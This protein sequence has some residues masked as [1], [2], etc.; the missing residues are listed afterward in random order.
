MTYSQ[1]PTVA[2]PQAVPTV[3]TDQKTQPL[4]KVPKLTKR[5]RIKL[6]Q[7]VL[8]FVKS[9]E[10]INTLSQI[11]EF[12][13]LIN[14][15]SLIISL[16]SLNSATNPE[17][18]RS[19][20]SSH[21]RITD[22]VVTFNLDP[23]Y[24]KTSYDSRTHEVAKQVIDIDESVIKA[25]MRGNTSVPQ[26]VVVEIYIENDS[27]FVSN[28]LDILDNF[29]FSRLVDR[30]TNQRK[31]GRGRR[32]KA[33]TGT[34]FIH[35][36]V[37]KVGF[38][39]ERFNLGNLEEFLD[40]YK[41]GM[42]EWFNFGEPRA[43][44]YKDGTVPASF[45]QQQDSAEE[46]YDWCYP[47]QT[48]G[49]TK[50]L[51]DL[52]NSRVKFLSGKNYQSHFNE[53]NFIEN[54]SV[55]VITFDKFKP[56]SHQIKYAYQNQQSMIQYPE[57]EVLDLCSEESIRGNM[58]QFNETF[59]NFLFSYFKHLISLNMSILAQSNGNLASQGFDLT[60]LNNF[61]HF[62]TFLISAYCR[63]MFMKPENDYFSLSRYFASSLE[64]KLVVKDLRFDYFNLLN[65]LNYYKNDNGVVKTCTSF[66]SSSSFSEIIK[67]SGII[68]K[69]SEE[70]FQYFINIR[71]LVFYNSNSEVQIEPEQMFR[72]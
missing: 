70:L 64:N 60:K 56:V 7:N 1:E 26:F 37:I 39:Q 22:N 41:F 48:C 49:F 69:I 62:K 3:E 14:D 46:Y 20:E 10:S 57:L 9:Y 50:A 18:W 68:D 32:G 33:N 63:L 21:D 4:K 19:I 59:T 55:E 5:A 12:Q 67:K 45:Q 44:C 42:F 51:F 16:N 65:S 52:R 13:S 58:L 27:R 53:V 28:P 6:L 29:D 43:V 17:L 40:I 15:S 61:E 8:D 2:S 23:S 34:N 54:A 25:Y 36:Q 31:R 35:L 30:F 71:E 66:E 11:P 47:E 24:F 38:K 72:N